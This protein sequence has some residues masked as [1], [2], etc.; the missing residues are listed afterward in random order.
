MFTATRIAHNRQD[1]GA[2]TE[3]LWNPSS[4]PFAMTVTLVSQRSVRS[5]TK[6]EVLNEKL[7]SRH[8]PC[9]ITP[10][11]ELASTSLLSL[12]YVRLAKFIYN[13]EN[14]LLTP[15]GFG[16]AFLTVVPDKAPSLTKRETNGDLYPMQSGT[17]STW[18]SSL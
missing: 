9:P 10:K 18:R 14:N 6:C 1:S 7:L 12:V 15:R 4:L 5:G 17:C 11:L 3:R 13:A 2:T 8:T 16:P